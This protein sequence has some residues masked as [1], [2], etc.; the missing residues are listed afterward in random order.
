MSLMM[1]VLIFLFFGAGDGDDTILDFVNNQY[2]IDLS[3]FNLSG[4]DELT[5]FSDDFGDVTID[6]SEH[7][8]GTIQLI[9]I[10]ITDMDVTDFLF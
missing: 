6:L 1:G 9:L 7:G 5:L 4:F 8:G 3:A 2:K 10:N